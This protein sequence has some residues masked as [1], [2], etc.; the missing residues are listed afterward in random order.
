MKWLMGKGWEINFLN[1]LISFN[2]NEMEVVYI[3]NKGS[4]KTDNRIPAED[5]DAIIN[6]LK[7]LQYL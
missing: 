7:D 3:I 4:I 6:V 1:N 2:K 5:I